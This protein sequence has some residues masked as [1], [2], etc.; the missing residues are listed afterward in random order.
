MGKNNCS[1]KGEK[2]GGIMKRMVFILMIL[3]AGC[4]NR[5]MKGNRDIETPT[6]PGK[7]SGLAMHPESVGL[8]RNKKQKIY[9]RKNYPDYN[10]DHNKR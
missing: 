10:A 6:S 2:G 9:L 4:G 3:L 7:K 8:G 5:K 1:L